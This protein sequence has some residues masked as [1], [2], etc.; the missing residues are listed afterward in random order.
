MRVDRPRRRLETPAARRSV[1]AGGVEMG[2]FVRP[3]A[4]RGRAASR[5][6]GLLLVGTLAA[7]GPAS[8][9]IL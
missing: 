4:G 8:A 7:A 5:W 3:R 1:G 9:A 6:G 2:G